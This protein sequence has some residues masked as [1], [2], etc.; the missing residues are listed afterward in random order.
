[1]TYHNSVQVLHCS[2]TLCEYAILQEWSDDRHGAGGTIYIFMH[3]HVCMY[4]YC[5]CVN[6][7]VCVCVCVCVYVLVCVCVC[8]CVRVCVCVCASVCLCLCVWLC[9]C[10]YASTHVC[11]CLCLCVWLCVYLCLHT[12]KIW[13]HTVLYAHVVLYL[14]NCQELSRLSVHRIQQC[15]LLHTRKVFNIDHLTFA[16]RC[17]SVHRYSASLSC[18]LAPHYVMW[19]Q[20]WYGMAVYS[21]AQ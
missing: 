4:T 19:R 3:V 6:V 12:H 20:Y 1:M 17:V 5:M 16:R 13:C 9:V 15:R 14:M 10:V 2:N 7:C 21:T 11:A 18:T 8:V